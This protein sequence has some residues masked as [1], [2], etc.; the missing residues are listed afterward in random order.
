MKL[1]IVITTHGNNGILCVQC[2][3]CYLRYLPDAF[4]V[5]YVN[6]SSDA[7]ILNIKD[8]YP[9]VTYVYVNDQKKNGGLT[10]TWNEGIKLC[11][12]NNC[13]TIILSNDDIFF[14]ES[15]KHIIE[16]SSHCKK[17][18]MKYFGPLTNNP[19]AT[20]ANKK[21]QYGTRSEDKPSYICQYNNKYFN[22]NGFFMVFPKHVLENNRYDHNNF[23][24]PSKPFEDNVVE[25]FN[26]FVQKKGIPIVVPKTF[27]YHYK[28]RSW[29]SDGQKKLQENDVCIY[30]IN[31]NNYEGKRILL[32]KNTDIDNIYFTDDPSLKENSIIH[33]CIQNNILFLYIDVEKYTSNNWWTVQKQVQRMIKTCPH[34]Y[35]PLNYTKSIYLDGDRMLT[36]KFCKEDVNRLLDDV[37]I[38]CYENPWNRGNPKRVCNEKK[39][40]Q[41][42]NHDTKENLDRIWKI[43]QENHFP[44]NIGLSETSILIR[45]H[46]NIKLFSNE[47]RDLIK[48]CIRDQM[49]FEYLLWKHKVKYRRKNVKHRPTRKMGHVNPRGREVR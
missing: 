25:W 10:A 41:Q 31:F 46:S 16:E 12:Q 30:T 28:L 8:N 2:L 1:G 29:R 26:R 15:V 3:E 20:E 45:N 21:N 4:I 36:K 7:K 19:G 6:E 40:I 11:I 42:S 49:S 18:E 5:L 13:E 34:D 35:L 9:S 47:W 39:V 17:N 24:D 44:D 23:F 37:D 33:K 32:Q 22:I 48:I 27:V 38:V 14:D 43:L